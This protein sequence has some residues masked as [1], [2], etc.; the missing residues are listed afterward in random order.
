MTKFVIGTAV[1]TTAPGKMLSGRGQISPSQTEKM[2]HIRLFNYENFPTAKRLL[3]QLA[4]CYSAQ[5]W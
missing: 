3:R 4:V 2:P 5:L 1:F